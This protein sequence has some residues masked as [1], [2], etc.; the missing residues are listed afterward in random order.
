LPPYYPYLATINI[1]PF[2]KVNTNYNGPG[3]KDERFITSSG[4]IDHINETLHPAMSS[5]QTRHEKLGCRNSPSPWGI[6]Q[7][8]IQTKACGRETTRITLLKQRRETAIDQGYVERESAG[9]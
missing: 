7:L 4:Q 8:A 1:S 5:C 3:F 6:V 9:A 2:N